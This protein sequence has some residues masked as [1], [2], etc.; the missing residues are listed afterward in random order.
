MQ[1]TVTQDDIDNGAQCNC[2]DCPIALAVRRATGGCG[3]QVGQRWVDIYDTTDRWPVSAA[4]GSYSLPQSA[5]IFVETFDDDEGGPA[6]VEPFAFEL[7][8][9]T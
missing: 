5:Q 2:T 4:A 1:I 9:R 3:V 6:A 7:A 8:R